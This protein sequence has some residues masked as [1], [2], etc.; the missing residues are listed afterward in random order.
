MQNMHNLWTKNQYAKYVLS[1]LL[2]S[3]PC[4]QPGPGQAVQVTSEL[5]LRLACCQC[6]G[7]DTVHSESTVTL[8]RPSHNGWGPGSLISPESLKLVV[9][10]YT[11]FQFSYTWR[12]HAN[13]ADGTRYIW[14]P[15]TFY[16][17]NVYN[18]I[19]IGDNCNCMLMGDE[20]FD[21]VKWHH[22]S[23]TW[24]IFRALFSHYWKLIA[25]TGDSV[26]FSVHFP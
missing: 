15:P 20:L 7:S 6:G 4:G 11:V 17:K 1:T 10:R 25:G 14:H 13:S 12:P 24:P 18:F 22:A 9:I 8:T 23:M 16:H 2:I 26:F 5:A 3:V 21:N 19:T